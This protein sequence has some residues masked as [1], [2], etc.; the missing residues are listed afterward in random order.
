M[1]DGFEAANGLNPLLFDR[2]DDLD[3]DNFSNYAEYLLG[4]DPN[5]LNSIPNVAAS[6]LIRAAA[7][8]L[9]PTEMGIEYQLQNSA[10][11]E[12][13]QNFGIPIQG[14]GAIQLVPVTTFPLD[15][16]FYRLTVP[17]Q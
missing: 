6:L 14:D 17:D 10:N 11:M 15:S 13:W 4:S 9:F 1:P 2:D 8:L 7:E 12:F 16:Q 5:D 3:S